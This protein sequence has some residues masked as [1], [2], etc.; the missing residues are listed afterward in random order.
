MTVSNTD[1]P[2]K[3]YTGTA[4]EYP[5][6]FDYISDND[7][8]VTLYNTETGVSTDQ[9]KDVHYTIS[10]ETVIYSEAPGSVYN[11]VIRRVTP[12]TQEASF[13]PGE[14]PPL[15]TYESCF[16]KLTMLAQDLDERLKRC[17]MFPDSYS[18]TD[19]ELPNPTGNAGKL[20]RINEDGTGIDVLAVSDSGQAT[21]VTDY[22][23]TADLEKLHDITSSATEI[24]QLHESGV[25]K[26]DFV[27]LHDIVEM[28]GKDWVDVRGY[29]DSI[30]TALGVI[31]EARATLWIPSGISLSE[32]TTIPAN[33]GLKI[34]YPGSITLGDYSLTI[35]GPFEGSPGCFVC[36]GMG[37][38]TFGI[39]SVDAMR[40][41]WWGAQ[42][43]GVT[44]DA[45]AIQAA[46]DSIDGGVLFF[47]P[48]AIFKVSDTISIDTSKVKGIIGNNATIITDSDIDIL[49]IFGGLETGTAIPG[50][51]DTEAEEGSMAFFIKGLKITSSP[52]LSVGTGLKLTGTFGVNIES[53]HIYKVNIGIC[54]TERNRNIIINGNHIW[55]CRS[56]G[57]HYDH[58]NCHQSII[59]N[60]HISYAKT[61]LFFD[62]GDVH[63][64]QIV[65]N[66][67]EG[68][69]CQDSNYDNAIKVLADEPDTQISQ[70]QI[71]GNSIEEHGY[72]NSLIYM[73]RK[74]FESGQLE[75][76]EEQPIIRIFEIVG[77]E[78]SGSKECNI[79]LHSVTTG[80][81]S[82]NTLRAPH[83]G[84]SIKAFNLVEALTI[85]G[86]V[87]AGIN[88]GDRFGG[89]LYIE[90]DPDYPSALQVGTL[91]VSNNSIAAQFINPIVIRSH[92]DDTRTGALIFEVVIS[93]NSIQMAS[94]RGTRAEALVDLTGYS[95][96][97]N[98]PYGTIG[99]LM[100]NNN[101]LRCRNYS[102]H[103]IRVN[104]GTTT[105][106]IVKDNII[107]GLVARGGTNPIWYDLPTPGASVIIDDNIPSN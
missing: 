31:G 62:N 16:D 24:N 61:P 107:R 47:R 8:L 6:P 60:N 4:T 73:Y 10:D 71:T 28:S 106:L 88:E 26:A 14:E 52:A 54:I 13:G 22:C 40:P 44:D 83:D 5:I 64:I 84:Y 11:V 105:T 55:N 19:I 95:I 82:N 79:E 70:I 90:S 58:A 2:V 97:I 67:I 36:N 42:G 87:I 104:A 94:N 59:N 12:Y 89:A 99:S 7:I 1:S 9:T 45:E 74:R 29:G 20:I 53:C 48:G 49:H 81:I 15:S 37:S 21:E 41:E 103:G 102:Q 27:K 3:V 50:N 85:T 46:V 86:N 68:G 92:P 101:I 69:Y 100:M 56:Y 23:D 25:V 51:D 91:I 39:G 63:N 72:G 57:I 35:N 80:V 34:Q 43:D 32:D 77:N 78:L 65:G 17:I 30:S 33:V 76:G 93:G 18:G 96:D 38:V 75:E 66:D 98:L